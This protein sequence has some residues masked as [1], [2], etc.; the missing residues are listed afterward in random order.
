MKLNFILRYRNLIQTDIKQNLHLLFYAKQPN[1]LT[2][3]KTCFNELY[4]FL[5]KLFFICLGL[6]VRL[7]NF[8]LM[9]RAANFDLYPILMA[10]EQWGF[11]SVPHLLWHGASVYNGISDDP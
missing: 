8:L 11:F 9:W 2:Y 4:R 3:Y 1:Y 10:I 6:F 7:E 5:I